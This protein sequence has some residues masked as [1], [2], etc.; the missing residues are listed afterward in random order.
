MGKS[1]VLKVD[2][3]VHFNGHIVDSAFA[4]SFD[5]TYD[6]LLAA[7]KE[8]TNTDYHDTSALGAKI[9]NCELLS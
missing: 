3:G 7:V 8:A 5:P 9:L 6:N 4:T 2:F 1:D